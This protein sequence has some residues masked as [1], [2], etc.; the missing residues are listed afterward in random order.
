MGFCL[1]HSININL[2]TANSS[3]KETD[4]SW[5]ER[6]GSWADIL[7]VGETFKRLLQVN[8]VVDEIF[9]EGYHLV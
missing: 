2:A 5:I 7:A 3:C 1:V 6:F 4:W 8:E 9:D